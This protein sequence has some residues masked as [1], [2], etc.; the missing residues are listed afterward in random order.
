MP[1]ITII[2]GSEKAYL[3]TALFALL[4]GASLISANAYHSEYGGTDNQTD[5]ESNADWSNLSGPM[6][7]DIEKLYD[8]YHWYLNRIESINLT[9]ISIEDEMQDALENGQIEK[10]HHL[11]EQHDHLLR[12]MKEYE[13]IAEE[14]LA[15]IHS[16]EGGDGNE[17]E[18]EEVCKRPTCD[19]LGHE[20]GIWEDGCGNILECGNCSKHSHCIN[21]I[22]IEDCV[23]KD[24]ESAGYECGKMAITAPE[25]NASKRRAYRTAVAPLHYA[26][27]RTARMAAAACV[28]VQSSLTAR[29]SNAGPL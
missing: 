23:P 11:K 5:N 29:E 8:L 25:G 3:L 12:T 21:G 16:L 27:C 24:C 6:E 28:K 15:Y 17:T 9:L 19:E 26:C 4:V 7:G 20:C 18:G 1:T 2:M 14:I 10:Y 13:R 22:C